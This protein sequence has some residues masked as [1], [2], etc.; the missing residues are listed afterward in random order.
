MKRTGLVAALDQG[1]RAECYR[2]YVNACL[3]HV[4]APVASMSAAPLNV[5]GNEWRVQGGD[6][7]PQHS[8]ENF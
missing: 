6:R 5:C 4:P 3:G 7:H 8:A 2:A 1:D